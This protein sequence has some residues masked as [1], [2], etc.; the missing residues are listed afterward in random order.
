MTDRFY[1]K[2]NGQKRRSLVSC[3]V[4]LIT[5]LALASCSLIPESLKS[6]LNPS[7]GP[8]QQEIL[9]PVTRGPISASLSFVGNLRYKQSSELTWKTNGVIE[10]VY[11]KV[12]D[13]VK[14]DDILAELDPDFLSSTVLIAEKTM[15]EGQ[16]NLEDVK[17]SESS[18]MQAYVDLNI[19]EIA[20]TNA[21]LEQEA[22]Y[23]P[24]A[25]RY[26]MERAWDAFALANLNFNYAKQDYDFQV[27]TGEG[28][29]GFE[30]GRE[31]RSFGGKKV[32]IGADSRSA[33]ERKFEDYVS[34]YEE[35][36]SA[37]EKYVWTS[38][39]P[40]ATDYAVAEGNVQVAQK[41]YEKALETYRSYDTLPREKDVHAAEIALNNAEIVYKQRYIYAPFDGTVT[42]V[43]AVES[44]YITKGTNAFRLD[45][46]SRIYIP[47]S[48]SELDL[49]L[50]SPGTPVKITVDAVEGKTFS[51]KILDISEAS[52]ASGNTTSFDALVAFDSPE[53]GL[54]A[55]MTAEVSVPAYEKD[56]ALLIP[57]E[58]VTYKDGKPTVT[59]VSGTENREIE[60]STGIVSGNV[61]E[62]VSDNLR[63][64]E[65][66]SV[67]SISADSLR[68]LGLDPADYITS[69]RPARPE[70]GGFGPGN[71]PFGTMPAEPPSGFTK[72]TAAPSGLDSADTGKPVNTPEAADGSE[73]EP[74]AEETQRP[75]DMPGDGQ[76]PPRMPEGM[77][78]GMPGGMPEGRPEGMP[79]GMPEGAWPR[80][81]GVPGGE[82]PGGGRPQG[83][84]RNENREFPAPGN[85]T[86]RPTRPAENTES[87]GKG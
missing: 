79:E 3:C 38:G 34:T 80:P 21:K 75:P 62:V 32:I 60:I 17:E 12:G 9:V 68:A 18:R 67:S 71:A 28:W 39:R 50:V 43:D 61:I 69:D 83:P 31:V 37:Y 36:V 35:L 1:R 44:Y 2:E 25:T 49:S 52:A 85:M 76:F 11:V 7:N 45:D 27:S 22:L 77:P 41:E 46:M 56:N 29:E 20:L 70:S 74:T 23:Y 4:L 24:R 40:S 55:G 63:E 66:L 87:S 5:V 81:E 51:G 65:M 58:A 13:S 84:G 16:E 33:R 53:E 10:K 8:A 73:K 54:L 26:E 15:I 86:P 14:K 30:E 47:L 42:S 72:E 48:I 78:E 57:S 64:G 82:R 6:K 19:K 59:V